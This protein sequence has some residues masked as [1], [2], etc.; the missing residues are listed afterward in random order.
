MEII[1][2]Q[3]G[4][5]R[6]IVCGGRN[7]ADKNFVWETLGRIH[8]KRR[9]DLLIEGGQ[10]T[11]DPVNGVIGADSIAWG[12]AVTWGVPVRTFAADWDRLG[13][14][15]GPIRN[16]QMLDEGLANGCLGFQGGD[17]TLDMLSRAHKAG[18]TI[19]TPGWNW[20]PQTHP[21]AKPASEVLPAPTDLPPNS[22]PEL[23]F[24]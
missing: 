11:R 2:T 18:I 14:A 23:A 9:I 5:F 21:K 4:E 16:Q 13:K 12:W 22:Y 7:F 24:G 15:A 3:A 20:S 17:G 1:V 19:M 6:L 10:V 8:S